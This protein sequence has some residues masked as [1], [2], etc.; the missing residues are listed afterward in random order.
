MVTDNFAPALFEGR[1]IAIECRDAAWV[2]CISEGDRC[3]V[4]CAKIKIWVVEDGERVP[5][6]L[7]TI[8]KE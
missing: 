2:D 3:Q 5:S 1:K 8:E 4:E 6:L 7:V